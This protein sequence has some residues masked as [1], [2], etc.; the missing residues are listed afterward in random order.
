METFYTLLTLVT[1]GIFLVLTVLKD[2]KDYF[3]HINKNCR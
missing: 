2:R 3:N 1:S